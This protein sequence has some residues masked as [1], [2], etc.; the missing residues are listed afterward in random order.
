MATKN[1]NKT[2]SK[3]FKYTGADSQNNANNINTNLSKKELDKLKKLS[4]LTR[5]LRKKNKQENNRTIRQ[6]RAELVR[7]K[8]KEENRKSIKKKSESTNKKLIKG[9]YSKV[10]KILNKT[11][12]LLPK[13][14]SF[15][16]KLNFGKTTEKFVTGLKK[17]YQK[18]GGFILNGFLKGMGK[19]VQGFTGSLLGIGLM[20]AAAFFLLPKSTK[21]VFDKTVDYL[22]KEWPGVISSIQALLDGIDWVFTGVAEAVQV[23]FDMLGVHSQKLDEF[24]FNKRAGSL[25]I[26]NES[27]SEFGGAYGPRIKQVMDEVFIFGNKTEKDK[28]SNDATLKSLE[29]KGLYEVNNASFNTA[30][31]LYAA[32]KMLKETRNAPAAAAAGVAVGFMGEKPGNFTGDY[33]SATNLSKE[34][35]I[36]LLSRG[37]LPDYQ[38]RMLAKIYDLKFN[39]KSDYTNSIKYSETAKLSGGLSKT[40]EEIASIYGVNPEIQKKL[41]AIESAGKFISTDNKHKAAGYAQIFPSSVKDV[42]SYS[43]FWSKFKDIKKDN[44]GLPDRNDPKTN[45]ALMAFYIKIIQ[46]KLKNILHRNPTERDINYAYFLGVGGYKQLLDAYNNPQ[47]RSKPVNSFVSQ[48]TINSNP[49]MFKV[50]GKMLTVGEAWLNIGN[51][52]GLRSN[53]GNEQIIIITKTNTI[54]N[55][56]PVPQYGSY[57][58]D[59]PLGTDYG[60]PNK[61]SPKL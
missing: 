40:I 33:L 35:I 21:F 3:N 28:K 54:S 34:E 5:S 11:K 56:T 45:L 25:G 44:E 10:E 39:P 22:Q 31:G 6:A 17:L 49:A 12:K 18:M 61:Q 27:L 41:V 1:K 46:N 7:L 38:R 24:V 42:A 55:P 23:M 53:E 19:L 29:E 43:E 30:A 48:S 59:M 58:S 14:F 32:G 37:N 57:G 16:F 20:V 50:N 60:N 15:K 36:A 51:R 2:N 8:Q 26:E 4:D 9:M 52:R 13:N 47:N